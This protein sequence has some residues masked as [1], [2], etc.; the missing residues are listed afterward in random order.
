MGFTF[1]ES[2]P[3]TTSKITISRQRKGRTMIAFKNDALTQPRQTGD[4]VQTFENEAEFRNQHGV[5]TF[6]RNQPGQ[7]REEQS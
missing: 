3:A 1:A 5:D 7:R 4:S 2:E 6:A